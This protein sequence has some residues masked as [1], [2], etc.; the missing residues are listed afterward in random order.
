[1]KNAQ[2]MH[3]IRQDPVRDEQRVLFD[4]Q[5]P[6]ARNPARPPHSWEIC[7]SRHP[8]NDVIEHLQGRR[9]VLRG[10]MFRL[11]GQVRQ[12]VAQPP[13]A[14]CHPIFRAWPLRPDR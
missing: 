4:D 1:M 2:H 3:L 6:C 5:L 8:G 7:Q 12:G 10:D 14:H 9:R 11:G 13:N